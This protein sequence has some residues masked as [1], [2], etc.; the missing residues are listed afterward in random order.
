MR[1]R[2]VISG[3]LGGAWAT[4]TLPSLAQTPGRLRVG[5][6]SGGRQGFENY[7]DILIA[8]LAE[9]GWH[10]GERLS[11]ESRWADGDFSRVP[12]LARELVALQP[13]LIVCTGVLETKSLQAATQSIPI[14]FLLV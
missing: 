6:L 5:Y 8:A 14:V 7:A 1:R 4:G 11:F 3:V 2:E 10:V 9:L 12:V 13:D